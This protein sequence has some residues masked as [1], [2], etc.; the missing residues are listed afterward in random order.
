M[1][2]GDMNPSQGRDDVGALLAHCG[3]WG[4]SGM[5]FIL[6]NYFVGGSCNASFHCQFTVACLDVIR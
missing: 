3:V 2:D 1:L 6:S 4:I 5:Q